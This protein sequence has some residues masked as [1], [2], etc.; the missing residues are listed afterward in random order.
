MSSFTQSLLENLGLSLPYYL[1]MALALGICQRNRAKQPRLAKSFASAFGLFVLQSLISNVNR[2]WFASRESLGSSL[3]SVQ[4][5][6]LYAA[7]SALVFVL[8]YLGW[9]LLLLAL[10]RAFQALAPDPAS[11][12]TPDHPS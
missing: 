3:T 11:G 4:A 5:G 12:A 8:I 2:A 10:H 1:A 9:A 6:T 7:G